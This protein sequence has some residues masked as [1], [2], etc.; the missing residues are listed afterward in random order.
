MYISLFTYFLFKL[1]T[2]SQFLLDFEAIESVLRGRDQ[3]RYTD[4]VNRHSI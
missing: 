4:S 1:T 2:S 3:I